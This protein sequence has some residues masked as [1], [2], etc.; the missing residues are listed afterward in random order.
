MN[1]L[2]S[3]EPEWMKQIPSVV[4]CQFFFLMFV[5]VAALA[6]LV[7]LQDLFIIIGSKG[8]TGWSFLLRAIIA[9][10]IPVVNALFLYILCTRSLLEEGSRK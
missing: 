7:V 6:G 1:F 9:F 5:L 2:P 10:S 3:L 4:I 8:K